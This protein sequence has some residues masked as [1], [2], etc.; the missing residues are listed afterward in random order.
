MDGQ[1]GGYGSN[2]EF[3][4]RGMPEVLGFFPGKGNIALN[5]YSVGD[6]YIVAIGEKVDGQFVRVAE[7]TSQT[8]L[9]GVDLGTIA[10][11]ELQPFGDKAKI[12]DIYLDGKL[13]RDTGR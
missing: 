5:V 10:D 4:L 3:M 9:K 7:S 8:L 2:V 6:R 12:F 13:T 1:Y 11:R